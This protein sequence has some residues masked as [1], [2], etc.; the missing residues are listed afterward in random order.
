M[1]HLLA[2]LRTISNVQAKGILP[3]KLRFEIAGK[4]QL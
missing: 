4:V 1:E 3:F 2:L